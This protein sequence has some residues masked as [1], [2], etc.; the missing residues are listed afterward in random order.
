MKNP[1]KVKYPST[2]DRNYCKKCL[3]K[4]LLHDD[5]ELQ[6]THIIKIIAPEYCKVNI[7]TAELHE[8]VVSKIQV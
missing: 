3:L 5:P 7:E 4:A 8:R 2:I 1:E 6:I